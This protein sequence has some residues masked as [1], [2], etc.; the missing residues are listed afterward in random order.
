V[1]NLVTNNQFEILYNVTCA[2]IL[3]RMDFE[4]TYDGRHS[5]SYGGG[6]YTSENIYIPIGVIRYGRE[7]LINGHPEIIDSPA[8]YIEKAIFGGYLFDEFGHFITESTSRM[9]ARKFFP[10]LPFIFIKHNTHTTLHKYQIELLEIFENYEIIIN[11]A[12]KVGELILPQCSIVLG[13]VISNDGPS[14]ILRELIKPKIGSEFKDK[15][16][17]ISRTNINKRKCINEAEL[18]SEL[19]SLGLEIIYPEN[20]SIIQQIDLFSNSKLVVGLLGSAWNTLLISTPQIDC[21]RIYLDFIDKWGDYFKCIEDISDGFFLRSKCLFA[22]NDEETQHPYDIQYKVDINLALD[23]LKKFI[24]GNYLQSTSPVLYRSI[25]VNSEL[26]NDDMSES[27]QNYKVEKIKNL[28]LE[29][30]FNIINTYIKDLHLEVPNAPIIHLKMH[31]LIFTYDIFKDFE[32]FE[33]NLYEVRIV[34]KGTAINDKSINY[35]IEIEQA[36]IFQINDYLN[37][38]IELIIL[39]CIDILKPILRFNIV[40]ILQRAELQIDNNLNEFLLSI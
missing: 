24:S 3:H 20:L 12:L 31:E 38:E 39:K 36:G 33:E 7:C 17:Y 30:N 2:P 34:F 14:N 23:Q 11:E 1:T 9:W 21:V 5:G 10:D 16:V 35:Y 40:D 6:I 25:S 27:V 13:E 8:R 15:Q 29:L 18:E 22:V 26:S 37:D 28:D 19:I 4:N 32:K